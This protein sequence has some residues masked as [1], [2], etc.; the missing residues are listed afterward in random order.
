MRIASDFGRYELERQIYSVLVMHF[1]E[2]I[3][4][5]EI[6]KI[7][8]LSH[9]KV[10]RLI[11]QGREL[12]M[13]EISIRSRYQALFD[14]ESRLREAAGLEA[15]RITP[16]TSPN[17]ET[18]LQQVGA[19]AAGLLLE[20]LRDGDTI[21]ITGGKGVSAVVAGL[22]PDRAYAVEVV[23]LT[24]CVQGKHYTDVNHVATQMA[25]KLGG[26][27]FLIH[28]PLFADS[29]AEKEMLMGMKSV[30]EALDRARAAQVAVLGIGSIL[31]GD[32]SY[33]DLHPG[34]RGN[35]AE[36]EKAGA[37]GELLAHLVDR[38]GRPCDYQLNARLVAVAP[39]AL[40]AIPFTIGVASGANKVEP[41]CAALRG[42]HVKAMVCDEATAQAVL[43]TLDG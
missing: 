1:Q 3:T 19:A 16:T 30:T 42:R 20:R 43:E 28:A 15:V 5:A 14:L 27:A 39:D 17:A 6:A 25:D 23:P 12:G 11:K 2:G 24:G 4:Q 32:S 37:A 7:T 29:V 38:D 35:R 31:S 21:C 8:G 33:Y 34:S 40:D 10:N 18:T 41:I 36:I 9:P 26:S 13:V 22:A